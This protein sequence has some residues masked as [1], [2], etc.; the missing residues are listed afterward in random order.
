M[1]TRRYPSVPRLLL[2]LRALFEARALLRGPRCTIRQK[3]RRLGQGE[4]GRRRSTFPLNSFSDSPFLV[5]SFLSAL[6][7]NPERFWLRVLLELLDQG[8]GAEDRAPKDP[9]VFSFSF[10]FQNSAVEV[11]DVDAIVVEFLG[12]LLS[13]GIWSPK[14]RYFHLSIATKIITRPQAIATREIHV[15][16]AASG[17]RAGAENSKKKKCRLEN[18]E[19]RKNILLSPR[20]SRV[21]RLESGVFPALHVQKECFVDNYGVFVA[22]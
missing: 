22:N 15:G 5:F 19:K 17:A 7:S 10:R 11:V 13:T 16:R 2:R 18:I 3:K 9:R 8:Q 6:S 1:S 20:R 4:V 12:D 14:V 21:L